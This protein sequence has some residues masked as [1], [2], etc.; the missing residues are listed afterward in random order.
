MLSEIVIARKPTI[1]VI[2]EEYIGCGGDHQTKWSHE[3]FLDLSAH[4][5][6]IGSLKRRRSDM[7]E[8]SNSAQVSPK[9]RLEL[10]EFGPPAS[11]SD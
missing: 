11:R 10:M 5:L 9:Q 7:H 2:I 6:R 8:R 1:K 4:R 3:F